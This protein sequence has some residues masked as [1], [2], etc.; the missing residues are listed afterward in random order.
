M[1]YSPLIFIAGCA[2][3]FHIIRWV[4]Q[5]FGKH[6]GTRT[7]MVASLVI[8]SLLAGYYL[9][10]RMAKKTPK[11]SGV[12][13]ARLIFAEET[14]KAAEMARQRFGP[15]RN[16]MVSWNK[17][18]YYLDGLW[19][20]EPIAD[21][22]DLMRFAVRNNVDYFIREVETSNISAADVAGTPPG[23]RVAAVYQSSRIDYAVIFYQIV[24]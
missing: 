5:R 3:L 21:F 1:P 20:A 11:N 6:E 2:G 7:A 10:L 14:R 24:R 19:T 23:L 17:M 22:P 12:N 8:V 18:I 15:G 16:Y 13:P 4:V 9:S